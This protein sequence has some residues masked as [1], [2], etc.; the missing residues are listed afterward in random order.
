[1]CDCRFVILPSFSCVQCC[2]NV[3]QVALKIEIV[4]SE[5]KTVPPPKNESFLQNISDPVGDAV[6][7][8]LPFEVFG[9]PWQPTG[10]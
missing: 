3:V 10:V 9:I 1:M 6:Q 2:L 4:S 8:N 7:A 5:V